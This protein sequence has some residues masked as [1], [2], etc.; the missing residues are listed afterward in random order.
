M[1]YAACMDD[2]LQR[3]DTEV[4]MALVGLDARTT[5]YAP[6]GR[7]DKWSIQQIAEHLQLAL[8]LSSRGVEARLEKRVPARSHATLGQRLG[9]WGVLRLGLFPPSREAPEASTPKRPAVLRTGA[10]LADRIHA[11]LL[12]FDRLAR[13]AQGL[14]GHGPVLRHTVLGPLSMRAWNRFHLLHGQHHI[15]QMDRIRRDWKF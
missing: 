6:K 11:A 5:Q 7:D 13:R 14:F 12:E 2:D 1:A 3:L 8:E 9:Q 15:K 10:Q 4:T